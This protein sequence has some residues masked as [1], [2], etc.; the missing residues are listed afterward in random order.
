MSVM[1]NCFFFFFFLV[2]DFTAAVLA[3]LL[4]TLQYLQEEKW[5][6]AYQHSSVSCGF[7]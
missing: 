6:T 3:A 5:F 7:L 4:N 1:L 2:K